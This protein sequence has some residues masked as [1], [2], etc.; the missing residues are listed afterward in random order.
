[1]LKLLYLLYRADSDTGS[2]GHHH[3]TVLNV[4]AN[5]IQHKGND[6]RFYSQEKDITVLHSLLVTGGEVYTQFLK[7]QEKFV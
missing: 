4:T 5:L 7:K 2:A 6:R 1:M 3:V